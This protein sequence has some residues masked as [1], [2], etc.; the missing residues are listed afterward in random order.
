MRT[1]I[2][3]NDVM[4]NQVAKASEVLQSVNN[5]PKLFNNF[6]HIGII[7]E[8]KIADISKAEYLVFLSQHVDWY[9][10]NKQGDKSSRLSPAR[11]VADALYDVAIKELPVIQGVS[12]VPIVREDTIIS[13][14]G[15]EP[16]TGNYIVGDEVLV[17]EHA[18]KEEAK[19][20]VKW[21]EDEVLV[22][23]PFAD[24]KSRANAIGAM[25]MMILKQGH[26]TELI[27]LIAVNKQQPRTGAGTLIN[28]FSTIIS[29]Q[30]SFNVSLPYEED[31]RNSLLTAA[32]KNNRKF[33]CFD[34][35][36]QMVGGDALESYTTSPLFGSRLLHTNDMHEF[37]PVAILAVNGNNLTFTPDMT[38]RVLYIALE[39][40]EPHP[41]LRPFKH[42]PKV[43][44]IEGWVKVHRGQLLYN[45]Y[46]IIRAWLDA[47]K[48]QSKGV[49]FENFSAIMNQVNDILGFVGITGL[50]DNR[51]ELSQEVSSISPQ[52]DLLRA[53]YDHKKGQPQQEFT[54][55]DVHTWFSGL[56]DA[57]E[58]LMTYGKL[59]KTAGIGKQLNKIKG[60]W[61]GGLQFVPTGVGEVQEYK[62]QTLSTQGRKGVL[63]EYS[64]IA[65][66]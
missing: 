56:D 5:P 26:N 41:E 57:P 21:L 58:L 63:Q 15:Y 64:G 46:T 19:E 39:Y 62:V 31:K 3:I 13:Q 52:E 9:G 42:D 30:P 7:H 6:G 61:Y 37:I 35:T 14:K 60:Q 38:R 4:A 10:Y 23:F 40:L 44:P 34:N 65:A 12:Y 50:M 43:D 11:V 22:D 53:L 29:G 18:S 27:P 36:T 45:L 51:S 2:Y 24:N 17:P 33:V 25:I 1:E 55:R 28:I 8:G 16:A 59:R 32:L 54:A 47:G 49:N 20:A 48:P 66:S